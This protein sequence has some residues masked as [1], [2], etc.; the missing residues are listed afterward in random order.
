MKSL[1]ISRNYELLVALRMS[2]FEG[3]FCK[4]LDS[5]V[6]EFKEAQKR[7]DIGMIL[8]SEVDFNV[9]RED[10]FEAKKKKR[11]PLIVTLPGRNGFEE[12]DF[13]LKYVKEAVGL[14]LD[15]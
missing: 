5:L 12:K 15:R 14:K 4:D 9:M 6:S 2:G 1:A 3:V 10:V 13:I 7:T 11:G 8:L